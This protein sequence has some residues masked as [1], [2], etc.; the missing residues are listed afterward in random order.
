MANN[1]YDHME[2]AILPI[3][4]FHKGA[5]VAPF[6]VLSNSES[7]AVTLVQTPSAV[8]VFLLLP[9]ALVFFLSL[10]LRI[11]CINMKARTSK[12]N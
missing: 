7:S 6:V 9:S 11:A 10:L 2:P 5:P 3:G 12:S 1:T 4:C 8:N